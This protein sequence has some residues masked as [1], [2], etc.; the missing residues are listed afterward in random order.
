MKYIGLAGLVALA[1]VASAEQNQSCHESPQYLIV[2][3]ATGEVGTNFLVKY[4]IQPS[5]KIQCK[6]TIEKGDFEIKNEWAE[7]FM[8]LQGDLL[9]LDSGTGPDP[10]GLI[11]WNLRNR[12]KV[13]TGSYSEPYEIHL[14][15]L[16]FWAETGKANDDNCPERKEWESDGLGSAIETRVRLDLSDFSVVKSSQTRCE[17]RQ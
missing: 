13:Y 16:E 10:R 4:K 3:G 7:Y 11:I 8:A 5:Q 12:K 9:I 6:Y 17:S 2:E 15:Y 1:S 14:G